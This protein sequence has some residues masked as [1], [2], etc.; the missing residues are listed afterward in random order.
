MLIPSPASNTADERP[1]DLKVEPLLSV[2]GLTKRYH[3][4]QAGTSSASVTALDGISFSVASGSTLALVG[5]SG[6]GKTTLALCLSLLERPTSG[7]VRFDGRDL[8]SLNAVDLRRARP[9]MQLVFQDPGESLNPRLTAREIVTEPLVIQAKLSAQELG[10]RAGVLFDRVG[11]SA[12]MAER[13]PAEFSGGQRQ[14]L[15]IARAL[16][17]DP[18]VLILDEA[19]SALDC[20]IQAQIANLLL[21][22]QAERRLVYIFI[23]HDFVMARH[24]ADEIAVLERGRIVEQGPAAPMLGNPQQAATRALVAAA[25]RFERPSRGPVDR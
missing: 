16:A 12:R 18:R 25:P 21:D 19:L 8:T 24:M 15:A 23:T 14:R 2:E 22:L 11:L 20:S 6:S 9:Q 10:A 4:A 3:V 17:L 1:E 5:E 13:R 7:A